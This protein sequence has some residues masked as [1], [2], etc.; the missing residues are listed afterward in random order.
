VVWCQRCCGRC[1]LM[2]EMC[3]LRIKVP[4]A[5]ILGGPEYFISKVIR[6]IN[7]PQHTRTH[8]LLIIINLWSLRLL[9]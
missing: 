1:H 5:F 3:A 8:T 7:F 6:I 2:I 4:A 9:I